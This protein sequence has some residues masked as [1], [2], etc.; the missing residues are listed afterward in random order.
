[1]MPQPPASM[2]DR[3]VLI[4]GILE[5]TG[6]A[7]TLGQISVRSGLSRS[8][9]HRILQQLVAA[10]W[11]ERDGHSYSLGLRM[12]EIGSLVLHRNRITEC[13]RPFMQ[14]L[15]VATGH[16]VHLAILDDKDVVYLEKVGGVFAGSLPSRVGGRIAAHCTSVGKVLLAHSPEHVVTEY[17]ESG[18]AARTTASITTQDRLR[19]ALEAIRARGYGSESDEAVPGVACVAA[20]IFELGVPVAALS[21]CGPREHVDPDQL[22][23]LVMRT[24]A[25]VSRRLAM[26]ARRRLPAA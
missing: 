17:L 24:A 25:D 8:A 11:L 15:F 13:S 16:V 14:D 4:M 1:H 21:V 9:V 6:G 26:P 20:P 22:K 12:F 5:R 3:V 19:S 2:V 10:R 7:L 23:G 18:L